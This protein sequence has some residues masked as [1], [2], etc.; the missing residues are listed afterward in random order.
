MATASPVPKIRAHGT[1]R[2]SLPAKI[3]YNPEALKTSIRELLTRL[4]C[5]MCFSGA[6]CRFTLEREY[7]VDP[8]GVL[9][10]RSDPTPIPWREATVTVSLASAA[11]YN[12]ETVFKAIDNVIRTIGAC[13]CHSG[14]DV[15]Y[16]NE[17]TVIG[18]N[19]Q[20]QAQQFGGEPI[21][22]G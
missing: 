5:P 16:L 8:A 6:D 13:P 3:A 4:G 22:N 14:F 15:S 1:V 2:V 21:T 12:I 11:R 10:I 17:L 19:P 18:I 20:G 9:D 7:V